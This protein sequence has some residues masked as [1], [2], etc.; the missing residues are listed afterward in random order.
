MK[1]MNKILIICLSSLMISCSSLDKNFRIRPLNN[2]GPKV[3]ITKIEEDKNYF[4]GE[5]DSLDPINRRIY[6]FNGV[7]DREVLHPT[8]NAYKYYTPNFFQKRISNFFSNFSNIGTAIN[9]VLQLR[10]YDGMETVFR[11]AI[12]TTVGV[13]GLFDPAT[14]IGLPKHKENL[15]RTF[16]HYGIGSGKYV[17]APFLG[18]TNVRDLVAYPVNT[19]AIN[20]VDAYNF[21]DMDF[22]KPHM[23]GLYSL[24]LKN[25]MNIYFMESDYVFEYEYFRYLSK[26]YQ[27]VLDLKDIKRFDLKK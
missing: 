16:A 17:V 5:E 19:L 12:N 2:S 13:L 9:Q 24:H 21:A 14:K 26:K 22:S 15:G 20:K 6:Y 18:P 11:F 3:K 7:L 10:L 25:Y 1:N 8:M 23:I 27:D 4:F